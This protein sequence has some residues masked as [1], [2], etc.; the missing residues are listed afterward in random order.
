MLISVP[1]Y[2]LKCSMKSP[3]QTGKKVLKKIDN[4]N[5]SVTYEIDITQNDRVIGSCDHKLN[6][7]ELNDHCRVGNSCKNSV[8]RK[9][10]HVI[11]NPAVFVNQADHDRC[12]RKS[13]SVFQNRCSDRHPERRF[14][15]VVLIEN[16]VDRCVE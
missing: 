14:L 16:Q 5:F 3:W 4:V 2:Y 12:S 6:N 7:N 13:P 9:T 1:K 15:E 8:T 11:Q 10:H